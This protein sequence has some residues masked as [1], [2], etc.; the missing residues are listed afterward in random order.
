VI[1]TLGAKGAVLVTATGDDYVPGFRV[2]PVDTT[3]AGDVFNGAL[4]TRL[5]AGA[6]LREAVTFA[7]AAAALSVCRPGAQPS[8]PTRSEIDRFLQTRT[9]G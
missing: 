3:A 8:I 7:H 2:T 1:V 5:G 4:A 6:S 9:R